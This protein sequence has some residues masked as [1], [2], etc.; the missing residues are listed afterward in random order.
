M[1]VLW[2][3]RGLPRQPPHPLRSPAGAAARSGGPGPSSCE[4]AALHRGSRGPPASLHTASRIRAL[5]GAPAAGT[6][7][8]CPHILRDWLLLEGHEDPVPDSVLG[9][10]DAL[11][12]GWAW[13]PRGPAFPSPSARGTCPL[14]CHS[15][16]QSSASFGDPGGAGRGAGCLCGD[17]AAGV[18]GVSASALRPH[19]PSLVR[20]PRASRRHLGG[21]PQQPRGLRGALAP[22]GEVG[23]PAHPASWGW[24]RDSPSGFPSLIPFRSTQG[25]TRD[26]GVTCPSPSIT[27]PR[28][29]AAG[30]L[31]RQHPQRRVRES[32]SPGPLPSAV[33]A[34][35]LAGEDLRRVGHGRGLGM[36][37]WSAR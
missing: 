33:T 4:A 23:A 10:E 31:S 13:A 19:F 22:H 25:E 17:G 18:A 5:C 14:S 26:A 2:G 9:G 12:P 8:T 6:R 20:E 37:A 36:T 29:A 21:G 11:G 3:P 27:G 28:S 7:A 16:G 34:V 15:H 1:T 32:S 35:T 30:W 24:R